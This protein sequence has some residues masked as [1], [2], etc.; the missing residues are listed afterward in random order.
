MTPALSSLSAH[1][2]LLGIV[3]TSLFLQAEVKKKKKKDN[4]AFKLKVKVQAKAERKK[5]RKKLHK[6]SQ[7]EENQKEV[8]HVSVFTCQ[9]KYRGL[10]SSEFQKRVRPNR[11]CVCQN[12]VTVECV[13]A[14]PL[15]T[16]LADLAK[17][18]NSRERAS[19]LFQWLIT[20]IPD[21]MFFR[22]KQLALLI[23]KLSVCPSVRTYWYTL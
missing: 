6:P 12:Q 1:V 14:E 15:E 7:K 10:M 17:V 11:V 16:L 8:P 4:A 3:L 22:Y 19:K 13:S 5:M 21:K 2:C 18:N 23:S 20:P 9:C